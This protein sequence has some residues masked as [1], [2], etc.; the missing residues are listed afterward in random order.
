VRI[1]LD[2]IL[3]EEIFQPPANPGMVPEVLVSF[4]IRQR[5]GPVFGGESAIAVGA[6]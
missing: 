1:L 3:S 6:E 2:Q 4:I 5:I